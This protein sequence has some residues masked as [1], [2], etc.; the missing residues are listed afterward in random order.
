MRAVLST[1][2]E[3]KLTGRT[4]VLSR[5]LDLYQKGF[6]SPIRPL[7]AFEAPQAEEAFRSLSSGEHIGK[8]VLRVSNDSPIT[9]TVPHASPFGLDSD[10]TYLLAGGLGG[11]GKSIA[12]W[13]V[14]RGA[15]HL[16]FLSRSAGRKSKDD[17][18]FAEL[19]SMGCSVS[20]VPGQTQNLGDVREAIG[21]AQKPI[22]GVIQLAM[23][24]KVSSGNSLE[25]SNE[26]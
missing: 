23:V 20:A 2:D 25:L 9:A 1:C 19:R 17:S 11:L 10:A 13:M 3:L 7:K 24:L 16:I 12:I 8:F 26:F 21:L 4:R 18:F 6:V 5:C 15:R 22:K 14:E